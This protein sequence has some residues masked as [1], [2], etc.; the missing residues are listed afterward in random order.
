MPTRTIRR[1]FRAATAVLA[2][3]A[4]LVLPAPAATAAGGLRFEEFKCY[5]ASA[6]D[7]DDSPYFVVFVGRPD[8]T[9]MTTRVRKS[10]WDDN[11]DTGYVSKPQHLVTSYAPVDSLVVV[12]LVEEDVNPD[13]GQSEIDS[14]AFAMNNYWQAYRHADKAYTSEKMRKAMSASLDAR[15]AND[16]FIGTDSEW[17]TTQSGWLPRLEFD[18]HSSL[19][20][21]WLRMA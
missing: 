10:W 12:T 9:N 18:D 13:L 4:G 7:G 16:D 17:V 21:A 14:L 19:Y 15:L 8:G 20:R 11:V 6:E 5:M 1:S 3:M 2:V